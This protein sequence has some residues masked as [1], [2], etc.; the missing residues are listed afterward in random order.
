M[1][2]EKTWI[3]A[4]AYYA[5]RGGLKCASLV[6]IGWPRK[7]ILGP[8]SRSTHRIRSNP[9][10]GAAVKRFLPRHAPMGRQGTNV[11]PG[12]RLPVVAV[13]GEPWPTSRHKETPTSAG[14]AGVRHVART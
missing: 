14:P 5:L 2:I 1:Q 11:G 10:P 9:G 3:P 8:L 12:F 7:R 13:C 4:G 6:C